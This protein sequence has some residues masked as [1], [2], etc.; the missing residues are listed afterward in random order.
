[1]K[2][3]SYVANSHLL[4]AFRPRTR[5]GARGAELVSR[6]WGASRGFPTRKAHDT[7]GLIPPPTGSPP[8]GLTLRLRPPPVEAVHGGENALDEDGFD[9][10]GAEPDEPV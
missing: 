3:V 9:R 8:R 4:T 7:T 5:P 2:I 6:L 10:V 1:M